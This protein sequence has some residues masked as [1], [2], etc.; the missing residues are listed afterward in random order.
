MAKYV[1]AEVLWD[2]TLTS[3]GVLDTN[4]EDDFGRSGTIRLDDFLNFRVLAAL[5]S[6]DAESGFDVCHIALN[7][8]GTEAN[9]RYVAAGTRG[10]GGAGVTVAS[11]SDNQFIGVFPTDSAASGS[12]LEV[13]IDIQFPQTSGHR[14]LIYG[15]HR[16]R[17]DSDNIDVR[18]TAT[19][20]ENTD[21]VTRIAF[22]PDGSPTEKLVAGSRM[23]V[24]GEY[25]M[26]MSSGAIA[27][28]PGNITLSTL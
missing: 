3:A 17:R 5:Q 16:S 6:D 8:D 15:R 26:P 7:N 11:I 19:E 14:R 27:R 10:S 9:Y 21:P 23:V 28:G 4:D 12:W 13:N 22:V 1:V 18:V 24:I 20:W 2:K 25:I